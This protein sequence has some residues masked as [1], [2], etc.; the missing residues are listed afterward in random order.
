M[1]LIVA[2]LVTGFILCVHGLGPTSVKT[3]GERNNDT[4]LFYRLVVKPGIF[5]KLWGETFEEV[6]FPPKVGLITN[7]IIY[8]YNYFLRFVFQGIAQR[9]QNFLHPSYRSAGQQD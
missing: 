3:W 4:R 1:K 7:R 8:L 9:P 2:I 5:Y 6:D